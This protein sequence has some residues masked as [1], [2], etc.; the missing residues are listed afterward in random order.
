M[1]RT[2]TPLRPGSIADVS[3]LAAS[4]RNDS[5]AFAES[6]K[7]DR[8]NRRAQ[9]CRLMRAC[10]LMRDDTTVGLSNRDRGFEEDVLDGMQ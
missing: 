2:L 7:C 4:N 9:P 8:A 3:G 5:V 10:R 6:P 1:T